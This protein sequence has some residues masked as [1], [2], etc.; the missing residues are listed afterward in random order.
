MLYL[1]KWLESFILWLAF[2][3]LLAH[4]LVM[5]YISGDVVLRTFIGESLPATIEFGRLLL[6]IA[7]FVG[8]A[9]TQ[10]RRGHIV[11]DMVFSRLPPRAQAWVNVLANVL[12]LTFGSFL[13]Y[14]GWQKAWMSML[15]GETCWGGGMLIPIWPIRF[16]VP[17]GVGLFCAKLIADSI[18]EVVSLRK[19]ASQRG[20]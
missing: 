16:V 10:A 17:V 20:S 9:W 8:L 13:V 11:M 14:A 15:L 6:I 5:F 4:V 3:S 7:T 2:V 1:S 18:A 12:T 19:S